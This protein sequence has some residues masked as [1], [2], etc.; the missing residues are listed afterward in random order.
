LN[1]YWISA[2]VVKKA[3][4]VS[5]KAARGFG[6]DATLQNYQ[7]LYVQNGDMIKRSS[8]DG[9]VTFQGAG[10]EHVATRG[11]VCLKVAGELRAWGFEGS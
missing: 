7:M 11:H 5:S 9:M 10:Y 8:C 2:D 6:A 1:T 3:G 4:R